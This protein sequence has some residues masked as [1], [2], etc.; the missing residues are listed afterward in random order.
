[1]ENYITWWGNMSAKGATY[2]RVWLGN[3][4]PFILVRNQPGTSWWGMQTRPLSLT[5]YLRVQ[6]TPQAGVGH[7]AL[8]AAFRLDVVL[9]LARKYGIR[10][11][12]SLN[13]FQNF[14]TENYYACWPKCNPYSSLVSQPQDYFTDSQYVWWCLHC[15]VLDSNMIPNPFYS[16]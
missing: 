10:A 4:S 6:E 2:S 3:V 12:L 7:I 9:G 11:L 5:A 15:R 13:T 1:M 14:R 16:C 8:D